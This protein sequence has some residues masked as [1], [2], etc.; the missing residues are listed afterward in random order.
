MKTKKTAS[1]EKKPKRTKKTVK[2]MITGG[3][4]DT[5]VKPDLTDKLAT[6]ENH[7]H[8]F[9]THGAGV[10]D[11]MSEQTIQNIME[12]AR[13]AYYN[14]DAVMTDNEYDIFK[15]FIDKKYPENAEAIVIGADVKSDKVKLP[16]FMGS[17]DKI[18]PDTSAIDR[19]KKTFAGPYVLSSKLDG[20][21]GLYSTEGP[22]ALY[23]R[24]NGKV[25]QNISKFIGKLNMPS[26]TA[27][28]NGIVV[29]GE[30]IIR[31]DIFKVYYGSDFANARNFVAGVINSKSPGKQKLG[32]IDFVAYEVIKPELAPSKQFEFMK[33]HGFIVSKNETRRDVSNESLS[34]ILVDWRDTYEYEMDG[35]ICCDDHI[36]PRKEGN[37]DYAFAFKM[38]LGDQIAEAK[39]LAVEWSPSKDGLLKPRI[40]IE[41]VVLSGVRIEYATAFNAEFVMKNK[42]GVGAKIKLIRSGDVIPHI[43]D[44]LEPAEHVMMPI[45]EYEW[46]G[47]THVDIVLKNKGKNKDVLAKNIVFF[48]KTL[49]VDGIGPGNVD[50]IIAA[51]H[52]SVPNIIKMSLTDFMSVDGFK[53]KLATKVHTSIHKS[54]INANLV[55][56]MTA[57]NL[58]GHGMGK[59]KMVAILDDYPDVLTSDSSNDEKIEKIMKIKSMAHKSAVKFVSHIPEFIS[60]LDE[61]GL[62]DKL[63]QKPATNLS[64]DVDMSGP[65]YKKNVV[66]TGFR[67]DT[68]GKMIENAGAKIGSSV[69][70]NTFVVIV[71]PGAGRTGKVNQAEQLGITVMDMGMFRKLYFD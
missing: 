41:P 7:I 33:K 71:K 31:T 38:V 12:L 24:G 54:I 60:F 10:L 15:E 67:D 17:M 1:H 63:S 9:R 14:D 27:I 21:S 2:N 6:V 37:P 49:E 30:F 11:D 46:Y 70:K 39:V 29:R 56:I 36:Y 4:K 16:Y 40:K 19:W 58:F 53:E 68:L 50:R 22:P 26:P 25:G 44:V 61:I 43:M 3:V 42:L 8:Q 59:K 23:T 69:S 34:Q 48:F 62:I 5:Y 32:H 35:I 20:V 52:D 18:K 55:D 66:M 13:L 47:D 65:L 57:S 64:T 45:E 28:P 51:G